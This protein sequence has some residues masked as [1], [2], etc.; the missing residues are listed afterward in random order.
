MPVSGGARDGRQRSAKGE[1]SASK[2]KLHGGACYHSNS[3]SI[4]KKGPDLSP[5]VCYEEADREW[6]RA[7][8]EDDG[9]RRK[10][11]L[12]ALAAGAAHF[13]KKIFQSSR[14]RHPAKNRKSLRAQEGREIVLSGPFS[15]QE[16]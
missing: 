13:W 7:G 1:K 8:Q 9:S 10:A 5:P 6:G 3:K 12:G 14:H 15:R 2:G 16:N 11:A 4:P